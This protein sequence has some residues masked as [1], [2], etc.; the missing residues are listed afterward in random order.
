MALALSNA[1]QDQRALMAQK[2]TAKAALAQA[3]GA[4]EPVKPGEPDLSLE[5]PTEPEAIQLARSQRKDVRALEHQVQ[6]QDR[7]QSAVWSELI[8]RLE[9]RGAFIWSDGLAFD[10]DH[11]FEGT[12]AAVWTPFAR[13]TRPARARVERASE[14][15]LTASLAEMRRGVEVQVV[16]AFADLRTAEGESK[17]ATLAVSQ[18]EEAVRVE[19]IRYEEGQ[20]T[21][22]ELLEAEALLRQQRTRQEVA[23]LDVIRA[24]LR[25][26]LACGIL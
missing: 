23:A 22:S 5:V 9:A 14:H 20:L 13:G 3:V 16:G 4:R 19:R 26:R 21:V 11:Y 2:V 6:A 10:T 24:R 15:A 25:A 17:A 8:P 7:R 1:R 12:V 18:A